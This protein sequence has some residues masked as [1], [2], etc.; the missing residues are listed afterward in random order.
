MQLSESEEAPA[1]LV[2]AHNGVQMAEYSEEAARDDQ[3]SEPEEAPAPPEAVIAPAQ[4]ATARIDRA[5]ARHTVRVTCLVL[6]TQVPAAL[7]SSVSLAGNAP[8]DASHSTLDADEPLVCALCWTELTP[9]SI[10]NNCPRLYCEMDDCGFEMFACQ[11]PAG[12]EGWE[13][14]DYN[15]AGVEQ[16][17]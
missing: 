15:S 1:P 4:V 17:Q 2:V 13:S 9:C 10:M 16:Y 3:P 7:T 11:C 6:P 5:P 8:D 12:R 14:D